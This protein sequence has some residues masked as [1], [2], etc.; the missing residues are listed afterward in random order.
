MMHD[1]RGHRR[2]GLSLDHELDDYQVLN[3]GKEDQIYAHSK[4]GLL[5][6]S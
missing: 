4:G 3:W 6:Y 5:E 2:G 1:D